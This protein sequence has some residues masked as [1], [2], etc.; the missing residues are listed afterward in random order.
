MLTIKTKTAIT[1]LFILLLIGAGKSEIDSKENISVLISSD[2]NE[3]SLNF[4]ISENDHIKV[5]YEEI[6]IDIFC[7]CNY[8]FSFSYILYSDIEL[9]KYINGSIN[10]HTRINFTAEKHYY[11]YFKITVENTTF[12]YE[13]IS[14]MS[15]KR[16]DYVEDSVTYVSNYEVYFTIIKIVVFF[17]IILLLVE[18]IVDFGYLR[19]E[20]FNEEKR[21]FIIEAYNKYDIKMCI[22]Y[23]S[24]K[25]KSIEEI[26]NGA[27]NNYRFFNQYKKLSDFLDSKK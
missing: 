4:Y 15:S 16:Y 12:I 8:S 1:L 27:E 18:F 23:F 26:V 11:K 5:L 17:A 25:Q 20:Y 19:T 24:L 3:R 14:I 13:N 22:M 7:N 2:G 21:N 6:N 10:N 9:I